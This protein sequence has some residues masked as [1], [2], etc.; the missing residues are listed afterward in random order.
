MGSTEPFR[1]T[2]TVLVSEPPHTFVDFTVYLNSS[3]NGP[4][5]LCVGLRVM[6][7]VP[8][9]STEPPGFE[10]NCV[11]VGRRPS[12]SG[13]PLLDNLVANAAVLNFH[14][15]SAQRRLHYRVDFD[16]RARRCHAT[17]P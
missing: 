13:G 7:F 6:D 2:A 16:R 3:S 11:R 12:Q 10:R 8:L 5:P 14:R 1:C 4:V 9:A 15:R 17:W